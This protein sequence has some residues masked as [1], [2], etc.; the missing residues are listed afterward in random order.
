MKLTPAVADAIQEV[1]VSFEGHTVDVEADGNGGAW[2]T[3]H[4]CDLGGTF[5]RATSW[6]SFAI[7][8][9]YPDADVYASTT[10][11][12]RSAPSSARFRSARS[13]RW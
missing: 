3:V 4:E 8:F 5:S 12:A 6:V 9:Q 10:K 2:V 7:T 1:R 13:A 11:T